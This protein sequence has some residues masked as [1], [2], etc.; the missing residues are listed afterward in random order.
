M[1]PFLLPSSGNPMS[2]SLSPPVFSESISTASG[3]T[4][5]SVSVTVT[6]GQSPYTYSWSN[7]GGSQDISAGSPSSDTTDFDY[8]FGYYGFHSSVFEVEVTDNIGQTQTDRVVVT[9]IFG[10]GL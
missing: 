5:G 6:G 10:E 2:I 8:S 1:L 4:S 9:L 3:S 7:V